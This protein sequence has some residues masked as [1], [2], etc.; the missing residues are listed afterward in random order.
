M[1]PQFQVPIR[2]KTHDGRERRVGFE[3]EYTGVRLEKSARLIADLVGGEVERHNRFAFDVKGGRFGQFRIESDSS[4]LSKKKWERYVSSETIDEWVERFSEDLIPFELVT[5]PIRFSELAFVEDLRE[6]LRDAGAVGTHARFFSAFGF[7]F[8]PE[9][10]DFT[11][12]T[13]LSYQ[14][15]FF[16]LYD[17]LLATEDVPI[18]RRVLPYIDPFPDTYVSLILDETYQPSLRTFMKD[19]LEANPTRNRALDWLPL[20]AYIDRELTFSYPVEVGLVKPRPTLHY[21][22]PSSLI[23]EADWSIASEWNK[24]VEI[25]NL[26]ANPAM[27]LTMSREFRKLHGPF[28]LMAER[29]WI[30]RSGE[31]IDGTV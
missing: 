25:E 5:P 29:R 10:P 7:Q 8:N 3:F 9:M 4:V 30:K 18:A 27:I 15:A 2:T 14:R 28:S 11:V 21:R 16:L 1:G 26:A 6:V 23:D 24:W 22:L 12:E 13:L 20:F 17:R 19:Y 31:L